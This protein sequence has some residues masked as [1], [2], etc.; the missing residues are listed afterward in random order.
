MKV[1]VMHVYAD[2]HGLIQ[3]YV[4]QVIAEAAEYIWDRYGYEFGT[5]YSMIFKALSH[6]NYNVRL[7]AAEALAAALDENPDSIQVRFIYL[8]FSCFSCNLAN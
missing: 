3:S 6:I 4:F 8:G 7:A 5:D 2:D 1:I